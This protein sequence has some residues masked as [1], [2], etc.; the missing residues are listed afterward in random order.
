MPKIG[1]YYSTDNIKGDDIG[2]VVDSM[3]E[4][5][6]EQ[7][8]SYERSWYDNNFFDDGHHFRYYSRSENKIVDLSA[9]ESIYNPIRA[10]PKASKQIRGIAN[11]LTQKDPVPIVYPEKVNLAA[12]PSIPQ[13]DEETQ[14]QVMMENPMLKQALDEAKRVASLTGHYLEEEFRKQMLID[15]VAYMLVLAAKH[16]ISYMQVFYDR[17]FESMKTIVHDAFDI[18]T[19]NVNE[20][21]DSPFLIKSVPILI[22]QIKS[23]EMFDEEQREKINPDNKLANSE[24]KEAYLKSKYGSIANIEQTS[25]IMFNEALIKEYLTDENMSTIRSQEDGEE[26]LKGREKGDTVIRQV[27]TGGNIPLKEKYIKLKE[28]PFVDFR[29]EAGSI[30]Q[31]PLIERFKPA[32]KSLDMIVSRLERILHTMTV[33][34]WIQNESEGNLNISNQAGGQVIKYKAIPPVQATLAGVPSYVFNMMQ[35]F[36]RI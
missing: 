21:E 26:I 31:V 7:R 32:N 30:Y 15:K 34:A 13:F 23:N 22:S 20:L 3:K 17:E 33:G 12:Y 4:F 36:I 29:Y 9:R 25:T 35:F 18:Y 8:A 19:T 28:Y 11:L 6:S 1:G 10:I 5:V 24:I 16:G 14:Q 2:R 27:F